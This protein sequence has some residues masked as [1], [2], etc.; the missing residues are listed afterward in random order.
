MNSGKQNATR[1]L[2]LHAAERY[3]PPAGVWVKFQ[4]IKIDP[5]IYSRELENMLFR[6]YFLHSRARDNSIQLYRGGG[7]E[8]LHMLMLRNHPD[9]G[10]YFDDISTLGV[11]KRIIEKGAQGLPRRLLAHAIV[12]VTPNN[13]HLSPYEFMLVGCS[14]LVSLLEDPFMPPMASI[15]VFTPEEVDRFRKPAQLAEIDTPVFFLTPL[16]EMRLG[17]DKLSGDV[18]FSVRYTAPLDE[19][20]RLADYP[21]ITELTIHHKK[22]ETTVY[23]SPTLN[24]VAL[25]RVIENKDQGIAYIFDIE[26]GVRLVKLE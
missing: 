5:R 21:E 23:G 14:S 15:N 10:E 9:V 1:M 8:G 20:G 6:K 25:P 12:S 13:L 26:D 11:A 4:G 2:P 24:K 17:L 3:R 16:E 7:K 19:T 22:G 18:Y